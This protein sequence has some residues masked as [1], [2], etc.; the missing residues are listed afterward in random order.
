MKISNIR[1]HFSHQVKIFIFC[2]TEGEKFIS[3]SSGIPINTVEVR[4]KGTGW[5]AK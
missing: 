5:L 3:W 2:E 4:K 1:L